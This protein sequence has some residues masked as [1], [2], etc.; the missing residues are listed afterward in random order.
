MISTES[1]NITHIQ[2]FFNKEGLPEE[3]SQI[4]ERKP[5][6]VQELLRETSLEG[7]N[8]KGLLLA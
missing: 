5:F 7:E 2:F 6:M 1:T 4:F 8:H 3:K